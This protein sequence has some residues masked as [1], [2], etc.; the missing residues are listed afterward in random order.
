[1]HRPTFLALVLATAAACSFAGLAVAQQMGD[2]PKAETPTRIERATRIVT[3]LE[4]ALVRA[5][6][7]DVLEGSYVAM[8]EGALDDAKAMTKPVTAD[9]LTDAEKD[10]LAEELGADAGDGGGNGP[11]ANWREDW[12]DRTLSGA[13]ADAGLSEEEESAATPIISDWYDAN[14]EARAERDSKKQAELKKDR[15]DALRRLLGR[16]KA[17]K[18]IT[19]LN[20]A[21][22]WGRGR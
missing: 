17:N 1:M 9:E 8:L 4:A 2:A 21:G 13:F 6:A 11:G 16:K 15:D 19:D 22:G 14:W 18:V 20:S 12:K 7:A 3:A 5:K 10:A